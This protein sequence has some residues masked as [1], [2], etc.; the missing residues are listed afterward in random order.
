MGLNMSEMMKQSMCNQ[1]EEI[2]KVLTSEASRKIVKKIENMKI[3]K[4]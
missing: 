2:E 3:I 4:T 1:H